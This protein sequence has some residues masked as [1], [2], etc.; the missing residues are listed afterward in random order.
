LHVHQQKS[1][2]QNCELLR[3]VNCW[4]SNNRQQVF[5][6]SPPRWRWG[7]NAT[8]L[9]ASTLRGC[10][11]TTS[12]CLRH[13]SPFSWCTGGDRAVHT[14]HADSSIITV[15]S[16]KSFCFPL[17][18]ESKPNTHPPSPAHDT[19]HISSHP[20]SQQPS[21]DSAFEEGQHSFEGTIDTIS[22]PIVNLP[23]SLVHVC[24]NNWCA[25]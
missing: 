3:Q 9:H 5:F 18:N 24:T 6:L 22:A 11:P 25:K 23:H 20:S 12:R 14:P 2:G 19:R 10:P 1:K 16:I 15:I 21:V 4:A 8:C 13:C 7:V 17:Q